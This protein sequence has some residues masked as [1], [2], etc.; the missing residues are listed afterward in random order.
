M[1][2]ST[3]SWRRDRC[4]RWYH[5]SSR[6]TTYS[7]LSTTP[8]ISTIIRTYSAT[9][10]SSARVPTTMPASTNPPTPPPNSTTITRVHIPTILYKLSPKTKTS[11]MPSY[12]S[13]SN[14]I[15]IKNY[16]LSL[17]LI[18]SNKP[19]SKSSLIDV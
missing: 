14:S 7:T 18:V 9:I 15:L 19:K 5:R 3:S 1:T 16:K 12:N 6:T 8:V 2:R 4:G 13:K 10:T 11:T 17:I